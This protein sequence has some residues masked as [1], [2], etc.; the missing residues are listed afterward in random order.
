M[1]QVPGTNQLVANRG[2][3]ASRGRSARVD[4]VGMPEQQDPR[5]ALP[6]ATSDQIVAPA[7]LR[8][9]LDREAEPLQSLR[10]PVLDRVDPRLVVGAGVDAR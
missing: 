3:R 7:L 4:G 6:L 9:P 8:T 10:Q 2:D 1:S 5:A